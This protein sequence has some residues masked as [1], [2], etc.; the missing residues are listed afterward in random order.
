MDT[1]SMLPK[2]GQKVYC[3]CFVELSKTE[4]D[5][6][7]GHLSERRSKGRVFA[8]EKL[9]ITLTKEKEM[10]KRKSEKEERRRGKSNVL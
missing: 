5:E 9:E 8:P 2:K 6:I 3:L 4:P 7:C 10:R 1:L